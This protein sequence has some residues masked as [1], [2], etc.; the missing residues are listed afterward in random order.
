MTPQDKR[1]IKEI[2]SKNGH[3][4]IGVIKKDGQVCSGNFIYYLQGKKN[5]DHKRDRIVFD[6]YLSFRATFG[7]DDGYYTGICAGKLCYGVLVN[8]VIGEY[9]MPQFCTIDEWELMFSKYGA[10]EYSTIKKNKEIEEFNDFYYLNCA[11]FLPNFEVFQQ[12]DWV[13]KWLNQN[14]QR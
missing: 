5:T 10:H 8:I 14:K 3:H 7:V 11:N 2:I 13:N 6:Q 9:Y 12:P 4:N 1:D